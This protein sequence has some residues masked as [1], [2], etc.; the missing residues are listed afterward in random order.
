M[1]LNSAKIVCHRRKRRSKNTFFDL[2]RN[3]FFKLFL[4]VSSVDLFEVY[5]Q[6]RKKSKKI[7][8]HTENGGVKR[9]GY[10]YRGGYI[11]RAGCST[12]LQKNVAAHC[13]ATSFSHEPR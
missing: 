2:V 6:K 11:Y 7:I 12:D 1:V 13:L 5:C 4:L 10:T 9:S 8:E 3:F